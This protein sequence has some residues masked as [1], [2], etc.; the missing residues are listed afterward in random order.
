MQVPVLRKRQL[1]LPAQLSKLRLLLMTRLPLGTLLSLA[2]VVGQAQ[3]LPDSPD[4]T[5]PPVSVPT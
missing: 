5:P 2:A 1:P 3:D 4:V